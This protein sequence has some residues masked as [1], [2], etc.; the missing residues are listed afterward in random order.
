MADAPE[1]VREIGRRLEARFRALLEAAVDHP[2]HRRADGR[3]ASAGHP[4]GIN[5]DE[6]VGFIVLCFR[7]IKGRLF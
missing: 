2:L 4:E 3:L 6:Y 7:G 1:A 5:A